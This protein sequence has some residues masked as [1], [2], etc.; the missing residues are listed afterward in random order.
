MI[1]R[2]LGQ[3]SPMPKATV[4]TIILTLPFGLVKESKIHF[5]T[6]SV[7]RA[8]YISRSLNLRMSGYPIGSI[9]SFLKYK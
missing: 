1:L 6:S 9:I 3:S 5:F 2:T 8:E 4:A 7:V